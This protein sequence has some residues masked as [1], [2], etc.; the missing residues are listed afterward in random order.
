MGDTPGQASAERRGGPCRPLGGLA[1]VDRSA[2]KRLAALAR[3]Y[4]QARERRTA[5]A[6]DL[7]G[8]P[9]WEML[10]D[11]A[12]AEFE[13]RHVSVK[14]ACHGSGVPCSTA[15][16]YVGRLQEAGF[17]YRVG[18]V[19]DRRR[20]FIKPTGRARELVARWL[21]DVFADQA[22]SSE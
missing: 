17:I 16:G 2:E 3:R 21:H 20:T 9:T 13:G 15:L 19:N 1:E 18:D 14:S 7:F 10:L 8:D 12:I 4:L 5:S 22:I 11:L 6:P